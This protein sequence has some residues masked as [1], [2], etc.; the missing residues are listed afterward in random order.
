MNVVN[1]ERV[2]QSVT[3]LDTMATLMTHLADEIEQVENSN[4]DHRHPTTDAT[5]DNLWLNAGKQRQSYKVDDADGHHVRP[6]AFRH[7]ESRRQTVCEYHMTWLNYRRNLYNN[8][9]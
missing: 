6:D 7:L 4:E 3:W 8:S 1:Y 2:M 5:A 9:V